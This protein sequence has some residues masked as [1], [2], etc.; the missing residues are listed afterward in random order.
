MW[1]YSGEK[2]V[3]PLAPGEHFRSDEWFIILHE[4]DWHQ[5]ADAYRQRYQE[6]FR[7]DFLTWQKLS[8][9]VR[10]CDIVF[11][12][13]IA[14][15]SSS[16]TKGQ[17]YNISR[18][19]VVNR[20][21]DLPALVEKAIHKL[22]LGPEN[23]ILIVLG[24]G[25]HWG[26]GKMPDHFPMVEAA[27]GQQAA[28]TMCTELNALGLGGLC[29][30]A[31]PYFMHGESKHYS[32][33][34]DSGLVYPH[35]DWHTSIGGIACMASE[36]WQRVW[37]EEI[38]P[39]YAEMGIRGL[40]WDEGFGHQMICSR[41]EHLHGSSALGIL[42]AQVR[43]ARRMYQA[44][45]KIAGEEGFLLCEGGSDVQARYI[46]LWGFPRPVETQRYTHPD[47]L[48]I[49]EID[50]GNLE[51]SIGRAFLFGCP[52]MVRQFMGGEDL[53]KGST[54]KMLRRFVE[55]RRKMREDMAPGYPHGF[56]DQNG[57]SD[58]PEGL[59]GKLFS[60]SSGFTATFFARRDLGQEVNID[61]S[62]LG[63]PELGRVSCAVRLGANEMEY[64]TFAAKG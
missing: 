50:V 24:T 55:V 44:W 41:P 64:W 6:T 56:R 22:D 7:N 34:A 32:S 14:R 53:L 18:G 62:Q 9:A 35:A 10:R 13:Q 54:L 15:P 36:E 16:K 4:G 31:H 21:A 61:A 26:W 17:I 25:P 8:P 30:Y 52:L 5:T 28:E 29:F 12:S 48:I 38:F 59:E 49:A 40:Y 27:G 39:R 58:L 51:S 37:A 60:D 3:Y 63:H 57:L 2:Q 46:D 19:D 47:K 11:D 42:T 43:G 23:A 33:E 1:P 45:R 20:F